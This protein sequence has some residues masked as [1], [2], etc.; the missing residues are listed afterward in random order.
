MT[1]L[2]LSGYSFPECLATL[3][4]VTVACGV[5]VGEG[6][7]AHIMLLRLSLRL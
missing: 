2:V 5:A 4:V 7:R 1:F 6:W 3:V